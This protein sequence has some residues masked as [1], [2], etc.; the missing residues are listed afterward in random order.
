MEN[1]NTFRMLYYICFC[2]FWSLWSHCSFWW[3]FWLYAY[4]DIATLWY[5]SNQFLFFFL[6]L[7]ILS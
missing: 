7:F 1:N 4:W 2:I 3:N 6:L 5:Y